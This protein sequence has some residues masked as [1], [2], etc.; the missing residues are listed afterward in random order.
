MMLPGRPFAKAAD[1]TKL[2][3]RIVRIVQCIMESEYRL[4]LKSWY[5]G[6][7]VPSRSNISDGPSRMDCTEVRQL[8][9]L[10]VKA[11]WN[12]ILESLL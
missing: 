7:R 4:K 1:G 2:G 9:S 3:Q 11:D 6:V 10:E 12:F 5:A 8:G